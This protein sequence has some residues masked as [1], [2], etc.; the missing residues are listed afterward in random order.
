MLEVV[1]NHLQHQP[2]VDVS[3]VSVHPIHHHRQR[4]EI[5]ESQVENL[6]ES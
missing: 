5:V 1:D 2:L 4:S 6:A 3:F